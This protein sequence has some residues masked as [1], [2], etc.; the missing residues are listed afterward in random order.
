MPNKDQDP[1]FYLLVAAVMF[2]TVLGI[3][4]IQLKESVILMVKCFLVEEKDAS[5]NLA[6]FV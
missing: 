2:I 6:W 5:S 1:K 3:N 4:K